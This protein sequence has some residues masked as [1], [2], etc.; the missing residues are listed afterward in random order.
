MDGTSDKIEKLFLNYI[1]N[2]GEIPGGL[3]GIIPPKTIKEGNPEE[4]GRVMQ[5]GADLI[6]IGI[7]N[8]QFESWEYEKG[9]TKSRITE[10]INVYR[11]MGKEMENMKGSEPN[12]YHWYIIAML[13]EIISSLLDHV[14]IYMDE[15]TQI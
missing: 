7:D 4:I 10:A 2:M 15:H 14:D 5:R 6:E 8:M 9:K 1:N 12:E 11:A 3:F 13:M